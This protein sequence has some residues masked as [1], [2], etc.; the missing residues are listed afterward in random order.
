MGLFAGFADKK[1]KVNPNWFGKNM[2]ILCKHLYALCLMAL[3]A[4][5]AAS[6]ADYWVAANDAAVVTNNDCGAVSAIQGEP[7]IRRSFHTDDDVG[8]PA[9]VADRVN[10]G[11]VVSVPFGSRLEMV[12]GSNIVLVFGSGCKVRLGGLRNF[13]DADGLPVTRLDLEVLEGE[14]RLQVRQNVQK[15]MAALVQLNGA[16]VLVRRGDVEVALQGGWQAAVLSGD[17]MARLRRSGVPGAPFVIAERRTVGS[18]GDEPLGE[19]ETLAIRGRVPFSFETRSAALP[20]LPHMS[21]VLEA[22]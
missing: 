17:A 5:P 6:A 10:T 16:E 14:M 12:T 21:S 7:T 18:R 20:P 22:P 15:P 9:T 19:D 3:F 13:A 8:I 11:D 2:N 1:Q 4:V